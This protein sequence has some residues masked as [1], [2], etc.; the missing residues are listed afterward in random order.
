MAPTP[1]APTPE[2]R[3]ARI[4]AALAHCD[5]GTA[6]Y[7]DLGAR[8]DRASAV[9]AGT[10]AVA[11]WSLHATWDRPWVLAMGADPQEV[12][13]LVTA[14]VA[15]QG[16]PEGL[17]IARAAFPLLPVDLRP[18]EHWEWDWWVTTAEPPVR[19]G[20]TAVVDLALDDPR[21]PALLAQASPDA[22][23]RPGDPRIL[24]WS[25]ITA[26]A[27]PAP[28]PPAGDDDAL[29]AVAALT[30][31]RP[32]I[33]H[34]GS[35]ATRE[36]W[37]G[38]GLARDLCGAMTRRALADGAPAVTLGMHAANRTARGV[39]TSLGYRL[40]YRWASGRVAPQRTGAGAPRP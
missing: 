26:G 3:A 39:Y 12:A 22:M 23:V 4:R 37:R 2:D 36:E 38:R 5:D 21:I 40:G 15:Q 14:L 9:L 33:P 11:W 19:P 29:V 7:L 24:R 13:R 6:A 17:T 31:M 18:V 27:V 34:L 20:E 8:L 25:G 30:T 28:Q 10:G 1:D 16:R 35:V 32:G